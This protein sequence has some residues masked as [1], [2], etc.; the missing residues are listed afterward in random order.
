MT[1]EYWIRRGDQVTGPF[2]GARI[3]QMEAAGMVMGTDFISAD[4]KHWERVD[5]RQ[6]LFAAAPSLESNASAG[7]AHGAAGDSRRRETEPARSPSA[8]SSDRSPATSATARQHP[9]AASASVGPSPITL[10]PV[11]SETEGDRQAPPGAGERDFVCPKCRFQWRAKKLSS[12]G[13]PDK[14]PFRIGFFTGLVKARCPNCA[15][16]SRFPMSKMH[17]SVVLVILLG[18]GAAAAYSWVTGSSFQTPWL[19]ILFV[20]I[21]LL[22]DLRLR[23]KRPTPQQL[24]ASSS[25]G[26]RPLPGRG[27]TAAALTTAETKPQ[28]SAVRSRTRL[29]L[30]IVAVA[31][32]VIITSWFR[33]PELSVSGTAQDYVREAFAAWSAGDNSKAESLADKALDRDPSCVE[34]LILMGQFSWRRGDYDEALRFADRAIAVRPSMSSPWNIKASVLLDQGKPREA[35][36][37]V[38]T[39]LSHVPNSAA[40]WVVKAQALAALDNPTKALEACDK[41][42]HLDQRHAPAA[43]LNGLLL[44]GLDRYQEAI[45]CL[46]EVVTATPP[47][48]MPRNAWLRALWGAWLGM[49][50]A[51][52]GLGQRQEAA[53]CAEKARALGAEIPSD[54]QQWLAGP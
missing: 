46:R 52:A 7:A 6:S 39:G 26:G 28:P 3:K 20:I 43:A 10:T 51:H 5:G 49:A 16:V 21:P 14:P 37:A 44:L 36:L 19:G 30:L 45:A 17:F 9:T 35:L 11:A 22:Y 54:L 38:T 53:R 4:R 24:S 31:S 18:G 12:F 34:A 2:S 50:Y 40:L 48:T 15:K 41:A 23:A 8:S 25:G 1:K 33:A 29:T 27:P 47:D 42:I 32:F 13:T